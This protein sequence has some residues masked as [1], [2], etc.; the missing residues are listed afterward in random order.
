MS[1]IKSKS[2]GLGLI[3]IIYITAILLSYALYVWIDSIPPVWE[4]LIIDIVATLYVYFW[5]CIWKNASLYDPY[6]SVAPPFLALFWLAQS[7]NSVSQVP[8]KLWIIFGVVAL[9]SLRLTWNWTRWFTGLDYEDWRYRNF[10]KKSG[11]WFFI[12]NLFG[13]QVFP[14]IM[15]FLGSLSMSYSLSTANS[16]L[17]TVFDIIGFIIAVGAVFIEGI[18]DA[19]LHRFVKNRTDKGQ[20]MN[21][22]LWSR[23]RHPNYFGE[24]TFWFGMYF[25]GL[26]TTYSSWWVIIGPIA[27]AILFLTY[28]IPVMD[29]YQLSK[30]EAY[31]EYMAKTPAFIPRIV[32]RKKL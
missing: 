1:L 8:L 12:I 4:L 22:G 31:K 2:F 11:K 25:F 20:I 32:K 7:F 18:A 24:V 28:S 26:G 6:W 23:S 17:I 13:I 19:Q 30:K 27:I 10:R 16:S 3:S 21:Q 15:V 9:W 29:K 5:S 14:T